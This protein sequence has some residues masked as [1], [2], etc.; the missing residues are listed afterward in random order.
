M[1]MEILKDITVLYVEDDK[2]VND[3]LT[4]S[5]KR[6]CKNVY[7]AYN[8]LEGIEAFSKHQNEI[9]IIVTDIKMPVLDGIGMIKKIRELDKTKPIIITSAHGESRYLYEAIEEGVASYILKPISKQRLKETL[10]F[11]AK[12]SLYDSLEQRSIDSIEKMLELPDN[13]ALLF[14]NGEIVKSSQKVLTLF[15]YKDIQELDTHSDQ[16]LKALVEGKIEINQTI[17]KLY[18]QNINGSMVLIFFEK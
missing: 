18:G 16:I 12:A 17:Y 3:A 1:G 10:M 13:A 7:S 5:L 6:I 8:G 2:D 11:T 9:D 15:G 4:R 14:K